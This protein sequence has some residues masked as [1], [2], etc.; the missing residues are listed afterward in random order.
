M[1]GLPEGAEGSNP[2][3]F[4]ETFFKQLLNLQ[5]LSPVYVVERAHRVSSGRGPAG[6]WPRAFL[7]CLLNFRDRD[8]ILAEACKHPELKY[9]NA[10]I[11]VYPDF[12]QDLPKKRRSFRDVCRCL[13]EKGLVYNM[14][15]PSRLKV[16]HNGS[17]KFFESPADA[18]DWLDSI[19]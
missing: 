10:V 12:S 3:V 15:Y 2:I 1:V 13:R 11:H 4:A 14:L 19:A 6:A 18:V 17:A 8:L 7:V 5:H 9:E 16:I